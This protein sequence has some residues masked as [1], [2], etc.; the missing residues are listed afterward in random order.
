MKIKIS[1]ITP[2]PNQPRKTFKDESLQEL[3]DSYDKLGLIQP[4]TVRPIDGKYQ[5]VIG[6]RRYRASLLNGQTE[7]E[8]IVREDIDDKTT[9][10]MQFAENSQ[11]ENV[12]PLE[13]GKAFLEHRKKYKM[14]QEELGKVVGISQRHIGRFESLILDAVSKTQEYIQSGELDVSTAVEISTIKDEKRQGEL[15]QFAVDKGLARSAVR[16]LK[17]LVEAQSHRPIENIYASQVKPI[18][19]P[20]PYAAVIKQAEKPVKLIELKLVAEQLTVV[21]NSTSP[22]IL[23][24]LAPAQRLELADILEKC[25]D[26]L[27][28]H[29]QSLRGEVELIEGGD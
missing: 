22:E 17:P 23:E 6:E 26:A 21:A 12:A 14:N 29:I 3:K 27:E 20:E 5:I 16:Q 4:I 25:V 28:P 15:A 11:Q 9:R 2:D 7:I 13:L 8:C 1:Q 24:M 18:E 19:E 10:E